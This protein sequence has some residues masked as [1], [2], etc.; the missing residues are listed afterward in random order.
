MVRGL[1]IGLLTVA[2]IGIGLSSLFITPKTKVAEEP[3]SDPCAHPQKV[4]R[5]VDAEHPFPGVLC[6]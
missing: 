1:V 6:Y 4:V 3:G 5:V 2:L